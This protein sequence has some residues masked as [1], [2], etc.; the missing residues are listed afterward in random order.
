MNIIPV[1]PRIGFNRDLKL[2]VTR[3]CNLP[4]RVLLINRN[5]DCF[6]CHCDQWLPVSLGKI[7]DF[8]TLEDVWS[9]EVAKHLQNDIVDEK[10]FSYC[11]VDRCGIL[12]YDIKMPTYHISINIDE[13]C[14]L[15]CPSCRND[16][17]MYTDGPEYEI[18]LKRV[19]HIID[20]LEKFDHPCHVVMSGDGDPLA[21]NIMR[22]L[23]HRWKPKSNHTV[24]LFTNGLLLEKQLQDHQILNHVTEFMISIDA[25]SAEVYERVRL[26]GSWKQL[27][28]NF[29]WLKKQVSRRPAHVMIQLVVQKENYKDIDNFCELAIKYD[30]KANITYLEDWK[31]WSNF[32]EQDVIG[33]KNHHLHTDAIERLTS[34]LKKYRSNRIFFGS[35]LV[36]VVKSQDS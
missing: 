35:K 31:T 28:K 21:S 6:I 9:C 30:F 13:S 33:N 4:N 1:S 19:N 10:K 15:R 32:S 26:G 5:G 25:G 23:I 12:N 20:L 16:K 2:K 3:S 18:K 11:A 29:D 27:I 24:R 17:I 8:P 14:N 34:S 22:P 36:E 7:E